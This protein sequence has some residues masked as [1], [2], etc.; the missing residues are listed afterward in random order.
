MNA[1]RAGRHLIIGIGSPF[2]DDQAGWQVIEH[3]QRMDL[4]PEVQ[5]LSLDRP[6]PA[7]IEQ[8]QGYSSVILIDAVR[9]DQ[10]PPGACLEL[11]PEQLSGLDSL[12][13]HGFGLAVVLR[14][15]STLAQL[16]TRLRLFGLC[17]PTVPTP[18]AALSP[19]MRAGVLQLTQQLS[20]ALNT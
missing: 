6:G 19:E 14:L 8:M 3:L 15:A 13:T 4:P 5:L 17:M 18:H 1:H 2:G 16:P 10:Y 20:A 12:S 7:L 9:T 11:T